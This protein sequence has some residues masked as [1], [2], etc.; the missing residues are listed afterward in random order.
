MRKVTTALAIKPRGSRSDT[1]VRAPHAH[2]TNLN[3]PSPETRE[4]LRALRTLAPLLG[5]HL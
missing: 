1:V 2:D 3:G 4:L 5:A